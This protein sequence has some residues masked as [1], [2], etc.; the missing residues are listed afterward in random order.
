MNIRILET[1]VW[2]NRLKNFSRT[3]EKLC[4]TQPA[5]SGRIQ[6]LEHFMRAELYERSTKSFELT[7]A[8]RRILQHAERIVALEAEME[9]MAAS[10][11]DMHGPVRVGVIESVTLSWLPRFLQQIRV[12]APD[13]VL[14]I[15]TGTTTQLVHDLREGKME[16]VFVAG[17]VNEPK[18]ENRQ[19]C[20]MDVCWL[21]SPKHFDCSRCID[22]L[23]LSRLPVMM[24]GSNSSGYGQVRDYFAQYGIDE[25]AS[26]GGNIRLDCV[27]SVSTAIQLVRTGLGVLA[28]PL[29]LLEKELRDESVSVL[30]VRQQLSPFQITACFRQPVMS[31]MIHTLIS[32]ASEA[33]HEFAKGCDR[34]HFWI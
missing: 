30:P 22:V 2:L 5:V 17:P 32:I 3:A 7:A 4:T 33:A 24:H 29:C 25:I 13:A 6:K 11:P 9:R 27:C 12:E 20:S 14:E 31:S 10:N 16:I 18:V 34:T 26:L 21:A 8:G 1:F 19:I 15:A 28:L 23:E